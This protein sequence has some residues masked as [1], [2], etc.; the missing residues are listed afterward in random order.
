M[1]FGLGVLNVIKEICFANEIIIFARYIL[2][3]E[4]D[5]MLAYTY[6][7]HGKFEL[8]VKHL[9][10]SAPVIFILNMVVCRVLCPE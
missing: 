8:Q 4:E 1:R 9:V 3:N 2:M 10:A 7:E 5:I 6:I